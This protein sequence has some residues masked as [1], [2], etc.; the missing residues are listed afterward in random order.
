[1]RQQR[2]LNW[3]KVFPYDQP[4]PAQKQAL[5][6][7]SGLLRAVIE[8]P[9]GIGKTALGYSILKGLQ[10]NGAK[11][12]YLYVTP[13]KTLVDQ[14]KD[15]HPEVEIVYGRNEYPCL[16]Y[17]ER[18][19]DITAE[20]APCSL[21]DCPHRAPSMENVSEEP[22][23][24]YLAKARIERGN[25]IA[26][27]TAFFL[28][29]K[30]FLDWPPDIAGLV[31][32][33]VHQ[34][35]RVARLL[36]RYDVTDYNL[37]RLID[38]LRDID[39]E[40]AANFREFRDLMIEIAKLKPARHPSLLEPDEIEELLE[41]LEKISLEEAREEIADRVRRGVIDPVELYED[42]KMWE[43]IDRDLRRYINSFRYAL[44]GEERNPLNYV[45][46]YYEKR[47]PKRKRVK[48]K[49]CIRAHYVAPLIRSAMRAKRIVGYSATVG[50]PEIFGFETG[51]EFP[52]QSY[53]SPFPVDNARIFLPSDTPNLAQRVRKPD[54]PQRALEMIA[55][56]AL[57][58][59]REEFRSLIVVVSERQRQQF[60]EIA[61]D[62]ELEAIS[63]GNGVSPK[64]AA[65]TFREGKG[66]ILVGT[67]ANYSHGI[68]LPKQTAPVIFFL[69][70]SYPRPQDPA[71]Q[72]EERRFGRERWR[73]WNW[74]VIIEALQV[75]GRNIRNVDDL[76]VAFFISQQFG[77]LFPGGLPEWLKPCWE[78][79]ESMEKQVE[80][81]IDFL[82]SY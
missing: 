46:A 3:Q 81:T 16:Y 12:A 41:Q 21:I 42:L 50:N 25:L 35:A 31:L 24:Y 15:L 13:T 70:P 18:G 45:F 51:I 14:V 58:F 49:L 1:M 71:T 11:G 29:N 32:D 53:P 17:Q 8:G 40:Q 76:G 64:D 72:F 43:I 33:E 63:Y 26:C 47:I 4:R 28:I 78:T 7:F 2:R 22:C 56:A 57:Q 30:I 75:R 73:V 66:D 77:R 62:T 74:R 60:L 36:F 79:G 38:F 52:F 69:K 19:R 67:A 55:K 82:K 23:P 37:R 20:E 80:K 54:D 61:K 44:E 10:E 68:D 59:A 48:Y 5:E 65:I 39:P 34:I 6:W 9:P 27:T